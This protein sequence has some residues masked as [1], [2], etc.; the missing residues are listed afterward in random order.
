MRGISAALT[1]RV[2]DDV[3]VRGRQGDPAG[4]LIFRDGSPLPD[5]TTVSDA[6][7][8][9]EANQKAFDPAGLSFILAMKISHGLRWLP[10]V[11][12]STPGGEIWPSRHPARRALTNLY[13]LYKL[14]NVAL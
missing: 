8:I 1:S 12:A 3:G 14:Y 7:M 6:A 9:S 5:V 2:P 13:S 10:S 11:R 4:D